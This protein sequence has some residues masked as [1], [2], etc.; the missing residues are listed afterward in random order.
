MLVKDYFLEE[1]FISWWQVIGGKQSAAE[2]KW[3]M[4]IKHKVF[5]IYCDGLSHTVEVDFKMKM[6]EWLEMASS[7][8]DKFPSKEDTDISLTV[9]FLH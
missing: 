7:E 1:T 6:D 9:T 8:G 3:G 5:Y 4:R 2:K